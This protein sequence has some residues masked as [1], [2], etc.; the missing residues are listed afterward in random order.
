V[1]E[2]LKSKRKMALSAIA[3][4]TLASCG[5]EHS[6][7]DMANAE[8]MNDLIVVSGTIENSVTDSI[9]IYNRVEQKLEAPIMLNA[10][11]SFADTLELA[12][13][14][15]QMSNGDN[16]FFMY[17]KKGFDVK[18]TVNTEDFGNTLQ[19]SGKG[20]KQ[21]NYFG[22]DYAKQE[23]LFSAIEEGLDSAGFMARIDAYKSGAT[24]LLNDSEIDDS[25]FLAQKEESIQQ[26]GDFSLILYQEEKKMEALVGTPSPMF[27]YEN[28][29]GGTTSLKEMKGKYV[30]VDV[31]ATWCGPCIG[32]IP[33][34]KEVEENFHG[35]NI[36][37]VSISIDDRE[38]EEKWRN[39]VA[40]RELGGIQLFADN[41]WKSE[42]V[43]GYSISGIPRFILIDPE[44]NIVD[45]SAPRPSEEELTETLNDLLN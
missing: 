13:G 15:Y 4:M 37:F 1:R 18:M 39:M 22:M 32:E 2:V 16:Y 5:G 36:E 14:V 19:F 7:D 31:W 27:D 34:L 23:E 24:N 38:D 45:G 21:N 29:N 28:I 43:Q 10:D 30:Y 8:E 17:L 9:A 3:L 20:D 44:G 41:S 6:E 11:G 12:E 25:T 35:K 26:T 42:F 40:D 33:Y